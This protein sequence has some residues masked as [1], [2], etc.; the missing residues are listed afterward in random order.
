MAARQEGRPIELEP[1]AGAASTLAELAALLR[2]LRRRDA[3]Q[4]GG[5]ESTVREL[6][7][8]TGWSHATIA[9]YL[10]GKILPRTDRFDALIQMLGATPA[11]QGA[12]ATVR[13]RV[14]EHRRG[15]SAAGA[16]FHRPDR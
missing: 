13:D 16:A 14:E 4:R 12:L 10:A 15:R 11:E 7:A 5:P 3:R 6:A 1:S 9:D 8:K 2:Q